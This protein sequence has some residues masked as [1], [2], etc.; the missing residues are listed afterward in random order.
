MDLR[1]VGLL[2]LEIL[3]IHHHAVSR[4][5]ALSHENIPMK[6]SLIICA[7]ISFVSSFPLFSQGKSVF[8]Y[9]LN[10]GDLWE[11][12]E[13]PRFF[14]YEQRK[15]IGD[16]LLSNGKI[17]KAIKV[18]GVL[19]S[20]FIFQRIDDHRVFQARPRF[21][22]PDSTAYDEF[23]LYKLQHCCPVKIVKPV[24]TDWRWLAIGRNFRT[25]H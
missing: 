11:Y 23:L 24:A 1:I 5:P 6:K 10:D 21:I 12:W 22:P 8:H 13:G 2:R 3:T 17:Y 20:G 7:A 18:T 19:N 4:R 25:R 15:V 9:P 14:I 16:S